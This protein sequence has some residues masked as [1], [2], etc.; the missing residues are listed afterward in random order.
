[1]SRRKKVSSFARQLAKS[2]ADYALLA[3]MPRWVA[4]NRRRYV[5]SGRVKFIPAVY[6]PD[7]ADNPGNAEVARQRHVNGVW[8]FIQR[9][10]AKEQN[11]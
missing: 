7:S 11:K 4:G 3:Y 8:M 5:T 9:E 1:M 6:A 2:D 10:N